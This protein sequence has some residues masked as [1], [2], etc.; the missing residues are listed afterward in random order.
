MSCILCPLHHLHRASF[1]TCG[2]CN[3]WMAKAFNRMVGQSFYNMWRPMPLILAE[4]MMVAT[5][6]CPSPNGAG[7][8]IHYL[9]R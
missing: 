6:G 9:L 8:G 7:G 3:M 5:S 1:K 4:H 2:F